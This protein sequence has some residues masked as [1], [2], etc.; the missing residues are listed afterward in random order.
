MTEQRTV[1]VKSRLALAP[2]EGW[3]A[4]VAIYAGVG[5]WFLAP[6]GAGVAVQHAFPRLV[7][8]WSLLYALGGLLVLLGLWRRS[9]RLEAAG[10]CLLV[11]GAALS[12][13][14]FLTAGAPLLPTLIGQGGILVASAL[15]IRILWSLP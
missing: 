15:R 13:I 3:I 7:D 14:A 1:V 8:L 4:V 12:F 6:S 10:L 9:P 5:H 2:F 11:S